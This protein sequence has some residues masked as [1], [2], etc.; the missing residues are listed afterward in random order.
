MNDKVTKLAISSRIILLFLQ[1]IG[2]LLIPDHNPTDVFKSPSSSSLSST[3]SNN[4]NTEP[5]DYIIK[6]LFGGLL[7]WD[8]EYFLHISEN[9]YTYENTT[10]FYPLYPFIIHIITKIFFHI[11]F[12]LITFRYLALLLSILLNIYFFYRAA[13]CLYDLTYKIFGDANKSWNSIIL[14]C[15]NPAS[16]FFTAPYSESLYCWLT[17]SLMLECI[18]NIRFFKTILILSLNLLCRSNGLLN[19]GY[20]C[21][22][23]LR[24]ILLKKISIFKIMNLFVILIIS[25]IPLTFYNFYIFKL[26]CS[27]STLTSNFNSSNNNNNNH[28]SL[29]LN[30]QHSKLIIDYAEKNN[31]ILS[32]LPRNPNNSLWCDKIIP[33]P[34]SYVQSVYWNVGFLNYYQFKQIPNFLLATPIIIL[35]LIMSIK[36]MKNFIQLCKLKNSIINGILLDKSIPFVIHCFLLLIFCILFI[37]IQ[38]TTRLIAASSPCLYW[39]GADYLPKNFININLSLINNYKSRSLLIVYWFGSYFVIGTI[40]FCNFYPWT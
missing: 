30:I 15:F 34:Y 20:P 35:I 22:F 24:K 14:F 40:L 23:I 21:Y 32:G 37:H 33:I 11:T 12:H 27:N 25:I 7:R 31:L 17:F 16:I 10:A 3:N 2:N 28:N 4:T 19:L 1:F 18:Q 39:Y 29:N 26:F 9:G 5:L 13:N 6:F 36:Y 38:V 8:A